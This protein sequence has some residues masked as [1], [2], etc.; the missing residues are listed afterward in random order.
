M[1]LPFKLQRLQMIDSQCDRESAR[2]AEIEASLAE[3]V[4]LKQAR[5]AEIVANEKLAAVRKALKRAEEV[6]Q[7]QRIKI[8]T[9]EASLYGGRV[10]NPKELQD[11]Q[12]E[13]AA[14]KRYLA[15]LEDRQLD[16]MMAYEEAETG[17]RQAQLELAAEQNRFEK[18]TENLLKE[19]KELAASLEP[20]QSERQ[21]AA[22]ALDAETLELYT[23]LRKQRRGVAVARVIE[24]ACSGCGSKLN[25]TLLQAAFLPNQVVRC[26]TCGRILYAV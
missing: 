1:S 14:L 9:N 23:H 11:I 4:R 13:I 2:L 18:Q 15:V 5:T 22:A 26:E 21:A 24:K 20:H 12:K 19:Q 3:D 10:S 17:L 25:A 7:E 8:E 16:E 6:V